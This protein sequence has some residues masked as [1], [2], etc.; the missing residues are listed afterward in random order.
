MVVEHTFITTLEGHDALR[1]AWEL[2]LSRGFSPLPQQ[3]M[4]ARPPA[5][6]AVELRR[7]RENPERAKSIVELPQFVRVEW[8]R[9]RVVVAASITPRTWMGRQ[10]TPGSM[11]T[12]AIDTRQPDQE[13]MLLAIIHS[14]EML[15]AHRRPPAECVAGLDQLQ[16]H[17]VQQ[18]RRARRRGW[19]IVG[20]VVLALIG[21]IIFAATTFK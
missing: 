11:I 3:E 19:L 17:L 15:L 21:F 14:L 13:N 7:G 9:G 8:D 10:Y 5:P 2:L 1:M 4:A 18:A 20:G 12:K 6:N 16:H